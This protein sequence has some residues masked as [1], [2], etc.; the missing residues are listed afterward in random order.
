MWLFLFLPRNIKFQKLTKH[1]DYLPILKNHS[2]FKV[3]KTNDLDE[4]LQVKL[5][6][7]P[8]L[9]ISYFIT[10]TEEHHTKDT[11]LLMRTFI[12]HLPCKIKN[13]DVKLWKLQIKQQK[14][15]ISTKSSKT[16]PSSSK[17]YKL[18]GFH[19]AL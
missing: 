16:N 3:N 13:V 1:N 9:A 5:Y 11:L 15:S 2:Y 17:K 18:N 6:K 4:M 8:I 19:D 7:H 12:P 14:L 10:V